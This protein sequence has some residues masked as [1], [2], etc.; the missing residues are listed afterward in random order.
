MDAID[1][2]LAN[3]LSGVIGELNDIEFDDDEYDCGYVDGINNMCEKIIKI[4]RNSD[5]EKI[6]KFYNVVYGN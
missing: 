3:L 1:K 5:H 4:F 2:E 6:L